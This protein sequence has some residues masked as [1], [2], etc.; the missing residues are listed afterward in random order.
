MLALASAPGGGG[1]LAYALSPWRQLWWLSGQ[2]CLG[3]PG[4]GTAKQKE[5]A[6]GCGAPVGAS[7]SEQA[8]L[9]R[10]VNWDGQLLERNGLWNC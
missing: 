7:E 8:S 4:L 9:G 3:S 10:W 5:K 2:C 6:A 1:H